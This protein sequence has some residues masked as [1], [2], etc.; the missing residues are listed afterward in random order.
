MQNIHFYEGDY[1]KLID[2]IK[3]NS[4]D[5]CLTDP[6]Y[7]IDGLNNTWNIKSIN[8][9]KKKLK[10]PIQNLPGGMKFDRKQSYIYEEFINTL[11]KKIYKILKPGGFFICFS[12]ARLY[13]RMAVA[14]ENQGFNIR[15]MIGWTYSGQAKAFSQNHIIN[16]QKWSDHKKNNLI[17]ELQGWKTPQL[18]PCIE[19]M[20]L[21]QKPFDNKFIDNWIKYKVG[22]LNTKETWD[23]K[24]PGNII[25]CPKPTKKEKGKYNTHITVK[26]LTLIEHL[27]KL[28]TVPNAQ[29]IDPFLGSGTTLIACLNNNRFGIGAEINNEY[30]NIIKQRLN[31]YGYKI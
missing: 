10:G 13:H 29:V 27:I 23:N 25:F 6:P 31:D 30:C 7:F 22:L 14:I 28:F 12:Q 26:P 18:K 15:D 17:K 20:C 21:A 24:F 8:D 3:N 11:A 16:K 4:I 19:P 2:T 5:L 9:N 1:V